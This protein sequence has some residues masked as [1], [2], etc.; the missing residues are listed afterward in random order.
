MKVHK[1]NPSLARPSST[2]VGGNKMS[3]RYEPIKRHGLV[4]TYDTLN[5]WAYS[6]HKTFEEAEREAIRLNREESAKTE[7][8]L[9]ALLPERAEAA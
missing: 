4:M 7:K 5:N 1:D 2:E 9:E 6:F 8:I 3:D